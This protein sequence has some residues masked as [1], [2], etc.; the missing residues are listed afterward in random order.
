MAT[1][2]KVHAVRIHYRVETLGD[3][4]VHYA[5]NCCLLDNFMKTISWTCQY[6]AA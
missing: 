5:A 4:A 2:I 1:H 3:N 6:V